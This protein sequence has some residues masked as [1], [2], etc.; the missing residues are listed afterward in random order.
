MTNK[1]YT[2]AETVIAWH[3]TTG[4]LGMTLN[5]LAAGA[6]QQGA[7]KD[8]GAITTP[9][10]GLYGYRATVA[11]ATTPVVSEVVGVFLKTS[12]GTYPDNDDGVTDLTVSA[13]D[14]LRNIMRLKHITVDEAAISVNMVVS[15]QVYIPAD[16]RY[17]M[18]ILWNYTA[19][20]LVATNDVSRFMLWPIPPELQ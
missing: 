18:P 17:V 5:N 7:Q 1:L 8:L 16:Q 4:D 19:D 12:D 3:D 2:I 13:E 9:R 6:G 10:S 15:G 14:K 11:F 20:N